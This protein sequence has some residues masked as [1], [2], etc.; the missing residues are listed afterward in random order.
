MWQG[1]TNWAAIALLYEGLMRL[2]PSMGAAVG[3]ALA[4]SRLHGPKAGR[5][6]L[7]RIDPGVASR[8]QPALAARAHLLAEG[9]RLDEART[10]YRASIAAT[11]DQTVAAYLRKRPSQCGPA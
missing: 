4:I 10:A 6:A 3:Q 9:G 11:G 2:A 8:H 7:G 1:A 5:V